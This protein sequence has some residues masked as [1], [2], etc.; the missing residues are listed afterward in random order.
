MRKT[1]VRAFVSY[2]LNRYDKRRLPLIHDTAGKLLEAIPLLLPPH[3]GR[4][5]RSKYRPGDEM[6]TCD[7][8]SQDYHYSLLIHSNL[9]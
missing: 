9:F 8:Y 4:Q 1:G 7:P 6:P 3:P 2:W 5:N